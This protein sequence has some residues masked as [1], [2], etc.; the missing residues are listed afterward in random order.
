M[1][2]FS[3][4]FIFWLLLFGISVNHFLVSS[5]L[6]STIITNS[7]SNQLFLCDLSSFPILFPAASSILFLFFLFSS[8]LFFLLFY[9]IFHLYLL[10]NLIEFCTFAVT[11]LMNSFLLLSYLVYQYPMSLF[12]FS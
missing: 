9:S 2:F 12:H 10:L 11:S 1:C 8:F 3:F 4:I 6:S 5:H 7:S